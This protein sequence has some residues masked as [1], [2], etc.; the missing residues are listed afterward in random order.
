MGW[1]YIRLGALKIV[2]LRIKH[3]FVLP[4]VMHPFAIHSIF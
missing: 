2:K 1:I 3:S 4:V